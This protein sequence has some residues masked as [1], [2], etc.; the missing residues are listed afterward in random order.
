MNISPDK[1]IHHCIFDDYFSRIIKTEDN[2]SK[3]IYEQNKESMFLDNIEL[4][5]SSHSG[6]NFIIKNKRTYRISIRV[7]IYRE[8]IYNN[9]YELAITES[10]NDNIYSFDSKD[11][12]VF[13]YRTRNDLISHVY[14]LILNLQQNK[15]FD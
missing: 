5:E 11:I 2:I 7:P 8:N 1:Y 14:D 6:A 9:C 13:G 15:I 4:A 3:I 12:L 10:N